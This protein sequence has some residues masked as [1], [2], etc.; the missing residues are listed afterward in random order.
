[1]TRDDQ[2]L[3]ASIVGIVLAWI[4]LVGAAMTLN[5]CVVEEDESAPLFIRGER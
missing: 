4:L 2:E 1:M 5:R 3:L